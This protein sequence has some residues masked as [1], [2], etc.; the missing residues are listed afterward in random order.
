MDQGLD[1]TKPPS[2]SYRETFRRHRKL[3]CIP[4]ILGALVAVFFAFGMSK[5]YKATANLWVDTAPP[6]ASSISSPPMLEPPAAAEQALL[7]ELLN[8][9]SFNASVADSSLLG[10][11]LG[12]HS[13]R[14]K[15]AA[16][17]GTGKIASTAVGNQV[18]QI[19][20]TASSPA[21][22][23]NVLAA[24]IAQLRNYTGRLNAQHNQA[25][26]AYLSDQVKAGETALA[27]ARSRVNAYQA[28]HPGV[29]KANPTYAALVAAQK[30][31]ARQLAQG[32][33]ALGQQAD[34]TN[35]NWSMQA[36]DPPT[37]VGSAGMSKK[38]IVAV[39][40]GGALG[41][42]LVSFL[43]VV[44]MTPAKKEVWEDELPIGGP[45]APNVPPA[46][47]VRTGSP[48]VPVAPVRLTEMPTAVGQ[49][50]LSL[51]GRRVQFR[52]PSAPTEDQ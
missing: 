20:Y 42:L 39:I 27:T 52:T 31:A 38:K 26:V 16:V 48:R 23:T 49:P 29:S 30:N 22:A 33:T 35:G 21:M 32:N 41:G 15:A 14:T 13:S 34:P 1:K 8:T 18:L 24:V 25:A 51:G 40:L 36:I 2:T 28:Q 37:N 45:F 11:S 9:D 46:D 6:A 47:P 19:S 10:K 12:A 5:P 43:A 7:S 17:L 3:F 44:A 4:P 50:R